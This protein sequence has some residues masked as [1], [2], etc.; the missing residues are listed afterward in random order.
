MSIAT[1]TRVDAVGTKVSAA[2]PVRAEGPAGPGSLALARYGA[3]GAIG[4]D[5]KLC[6][7][8]PVGPDEAETAVPV[9]GRKAL[10]SSDS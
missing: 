4:K 8:M 6:Q 10:V 3:L 7:F 9:T 5:G 1:W 2:R